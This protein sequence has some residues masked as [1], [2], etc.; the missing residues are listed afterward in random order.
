MRFRYFT[1]ALTD[2]PKLCV[3]GLLPGVGVHLSHWDGN[4]TPTHLKADTS[5]E[6][7]LNFVRAEPDRPVAP[8]VSLVSNNHFDTDGALSVWAALHGERALD[9]RDLLV[10]AAEAGDFCE[11]SSEA[12]VRV[13]LALQGTD[14]APW[15]LAPG[16]AGDEARAYELALPRIGELLRDPGAFER[17]WR[18]G[19]DRLMAAVDSFTRGASTVANVLDGRL[20]LVVL[21]PSIARG[22]RFHPTTGDLPSMAISTRARGEWIAVAT[23]RPG[24]WTWRVERAFH[25]W[26]DT[27]VR[28][29]YQ[30]RPAA[31]AVAALAAL[32]PS[33]AGEWR[34]G[35]GSMGPVLTYA[36][37]DGT[38]AVSRLS[39]DEVAAALAGALTTSRAALGPPV[40]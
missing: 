25:A 22:G 9:H 32:E 29:R 39:P 23:P 20:S 30:R 3:D 33:G 16:A 26:A 11:L 37:A 31:P 24:G 34:A 27:V 14:D 5:T 13:S 8:G 2:V 7:A 28:P 12:G 17:L 1:E 21:D 15:P 35:K 10:A 40:A 19:W 4:A 18:N 36:A 38:P 6:I